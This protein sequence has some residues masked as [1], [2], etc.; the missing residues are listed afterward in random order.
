MSIQRHFVFVVFNDPTVVG[1]LDFLHSTMMHT[2]LPSKP[3]ITIQGPFDEKVGA[4]RI[5]K[6]SEALSGDSFFIGNC[7]YF[8]SNGRC[9][10]FLRAASENLERVWVKPDFPKEKF[11]FNPHITFYEGGD[12]ERVKRA[13]KFLSKNRVE[14]MCS[15]FEVV[16]YVPRQMDM[17]PNEGVAGDTHAISRLIAQG[18]IAPTF[19]TG[20]LS[21]TS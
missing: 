14:L 3:H 1:V 17:F 7:G 2:R 4:D 11:G 13:H 19:R 12:V 9:S 8:E 20:F 16:Q 5:H 15:Q 21:A 10:L 18:R 6:I